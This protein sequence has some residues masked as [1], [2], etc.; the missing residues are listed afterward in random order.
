MFSELLLSARNVAL[1]VHIVT[2]SIALLA[3]AFAL[4]AMKGGVMH[5]RG[6]QVYA[7]AMMGLLATGAG[8][9]FARIDPF[10]AI[11]A[12]FALYL[13]ATSWWTLRKPPWPTALLALVALGCGAVDLLLGLYA[14]AQPSGRLMGYPPSGYFG[15]AVF[16]V[17]AAAG[18]LVHAR[19]RYGRAAVLGRHAWRMCIPLTMTAGSLFLGQQQVLPEALRG[20][21]L[22]L[23][24]SVAP[25]VP[26][27]LWLVRL[28]RA[29]LHR[30]ELRGEIA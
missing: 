6:G 28:G 14:L 30:Y 19:M 18:D 13:V 4:L 24:I 15:F 7:T 21:P 29:Q 1:I 9:A 10:V 25:L 23:A 16:A 22:L 3:G 26:L 20:S 2:G 11:N 5:R 27:F 17:A 12:I 8:L